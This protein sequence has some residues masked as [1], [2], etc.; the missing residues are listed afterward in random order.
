[1]LALVGP[2]VGPCGY[3][4]NPD[5]RHRV[6]DAIAARFDSGDPV[7]VLV[8]DYGVPSDTVHQLAESWPRA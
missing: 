3:C 6:A 8:E 2:P 1:M 4:R 7:D 5:A